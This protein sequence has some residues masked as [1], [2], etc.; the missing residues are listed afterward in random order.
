MSVEGLTLLIVNA[1]AAAI[2]GRLRSLPLTVA[3]GLLIGL[4]S[5]F[6][7]SFLDLSGRW[8][9]VQ[10][11]IPTI[12]LFVALLALPAAP[13]VA[14]GARLACTH[15]CRDCGRPRSVASSSSPSLPSSRP[16]WE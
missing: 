11:A 10:Q 14:D 15:A 5:A 7:L 12:V 8:A 2:I 4:L 6:S 13:I 16:G 3:G 9:G 1:F